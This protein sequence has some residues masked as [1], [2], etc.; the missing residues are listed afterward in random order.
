MNKDSTTSSTIEQIM[1]LTNINATNIINE[2]HYKY[3][4]FKSQLIK[5]KKNNSINTLTKN[6][7]HVINKFSVLKQELYEV[8]T[9]DYEFQHYCKLLLINL[10]KQFPDT[11]IIV[12]TKN[13]LI[14][15]KGFDCYNTLQFTITKGPKIYITPVFSL[16]EELMESIIK[17]HQEELDED[18]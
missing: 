8:D 3:A 10:T 13:A 14:F 9:T 18:F 12:C 17:K 4:K 5:L 7:K 16:N 1:Q 11:D 6:E 2:D 15:H